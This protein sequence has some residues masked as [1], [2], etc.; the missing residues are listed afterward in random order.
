LRGGGAH[1]RSRQAGRAGE[2]VAGGRGAA[3]HQ[4][5]PPQRLTAILIWSAISA[6]FIGPGTVTTASRAGAAHGLSLLWAVLFSTLACLSLQEASARLTVATGRPLGRLLRERWP[7]PLWLPALVV[8]AVVFGC[9]AYEM[10]NLLGAVAGG[11]LALGPLDLSPRSTELIRV[12]STLL[13]ALLAGAVLLV[14]SARAVARILGLV[15]AMMG[16]AFLL[17][18]A[19]LAP[20]AL[21]LLKGLGGLSLPAGSGLLA[22]GLVGT[23]VVPY[24]LFLGSGLARGRPLSEARL[25][26]LVAVPLGGILTMAI[27]VAGTAV[28]GEYSFEALAAAL[29]GELGP[30]ARVLFALGL[31]AAGLSS[32][33]TAPLAAA[34][35]V[36]GLLGR[37]ATDRSWGDR[38]GRYRALWGGV[39]AIGLL[40]A[41]TRA[42]PIPTIILAQA[43]NGVV[44]PLVA[45]Y[46]WL[47]VNDRRLMGDA[48]LCGPLANAALAAAVLV[49]IL[50][51]TAG[52]L[53]A[54]WR[55]MG[56][57]S[58]AERSLLPVAAALTAVVAIP[59]VRAVR[60]GR[61]RVARQVAM[62]RR[63]A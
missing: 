53:G 50:L 35:S 24:N 49:T 14:G 34:L 11:L 4:I 59:V 18:A 37:E 32:A 56:A 51:G 9:A 27:L 28:S 19:R 41:L 15:V 57:G 46:L 23:T 40:F 6:A 44:L 3:R 54:A 45:V 5:S 38:G 61:R 17:C 29:R 22:L 20:P 42:Q 30:G 63:P 58:V 25:G 33:I 21:A 12:G 7:R 47:G 55:A 39:L 48:H 62:G 13:M 10:G 36:Q 8:G 1:G 2:A 52:V 26:L 16:A 31:L 60:G 43:L